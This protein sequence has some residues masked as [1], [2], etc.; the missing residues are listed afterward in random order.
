MRIQDGHRRIILNLHPDS[1]INPL[2]EARE[3]LSSLVVDVSTRG[4][5]RA[6]PFLLCKR[7]VYSFCVSAREAEVHATRLTFH[8]RDG[9]A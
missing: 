5:V 6:L 9:I 3:D 7:P 1:I 8:R 2:A 4:I